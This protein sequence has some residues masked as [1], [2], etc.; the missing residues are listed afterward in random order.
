[1][2]DHPEQANALRTLQDWQR[3][4]EIELALYGTCN[5]DARHIPSEF[6]A[7]VIRDVYAQWQTRKF[8]ARALRWMRSLP[9]CDSCQLCVNTKLGPFEQRFIV[10][11]KCGNK[12][13]PKANNHR[14]TCARS[15]ESGQVGSAYE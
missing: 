11:A 9:E 3:E 8:Q 2:T 6:C 14:H 7:L 13:C 1:M 12:R 4:V 15:N 10:C 5:V